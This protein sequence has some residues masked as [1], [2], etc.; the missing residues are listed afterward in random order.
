[1]ENSGKLESL[2]DILMR[3]N[4]T[5]NFRQT[6]TVIPALALIL[7][8]LPLSGLGQNYDKLNRF[9]QKVSASDSAMKL[10][11]QGRNQ[12]EEAQWDKAAQSFNRFIAEYPR[13]KDV[14]VALY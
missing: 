4:M 5:G 2:P 14:D 7:T 13:H 11:Q 8:V 3:I 6:I 10:I 9:M 12:I 1:M